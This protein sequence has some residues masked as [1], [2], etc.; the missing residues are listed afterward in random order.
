MGKS[1]PRK[2][3]EKNGG[4]Y[5][6]LTSLFDCKV[7]KEGRK[8][9]WRLREGGR[10]EMKGIDVELNQSSRSPARPIYVIWCSWGS[11][12]QIAYWRQLKK[13]TS[14]FIIRL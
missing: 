11:C 1:F 14:I 7:G 4:R 13:N 2:E 10:R 6:R 8:G 5:S 3:K 9:G 12:L